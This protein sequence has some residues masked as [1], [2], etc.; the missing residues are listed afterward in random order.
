MGQK[1]ESLLNIRY[2]SNIFT[3][4]NYLKV[5]FVSFC[6][7]LKEYLFFMICEEKVRRKCKK[8]WKLRRAFH[9]G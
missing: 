8:Y 2:K 9:K 1:C 6:Q 3:T 7:H 5:V 4:F